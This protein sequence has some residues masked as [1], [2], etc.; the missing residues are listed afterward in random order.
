MLK[1]KI[2]NT[3][4]R[5]NQSKHEIKKIYSIGH[6][7]HSVAEFLALL[8]A[9]HI[10][11]VIDVRSIPKSHHCPQFNK[12]RL[13]Q[14]LKIEKITYRHMKELGGF[15]KTVKNSVNDGWENA[16]FRGYADYMSTPAFQEGLEKLEKIAKKKRCVLM[17][18]EAV[19]WR[20]HR[21]LIFDALSIKRWKAFHIQ[22][23]K[24]AK[25]HKITSFAK[26]RNGCLIYPL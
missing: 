17:C 14:L 22:S 21:S 11:C 18:A 7:T 5:I 1:N 23:Q 6:S 3:L 2:A 13:K 24:T 26:I 10:E 19:P 4:N 20:C 12:D 16:S 15:R 8:K 9:H 25:Q